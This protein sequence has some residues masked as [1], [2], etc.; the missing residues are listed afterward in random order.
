[1]QN[2]R[3]L[4]TVAKHEKKLIAQLESTREEARIIVNEAQD[5]ASILLQEAQQKLDAELNTMRREALESR[6]HATN[7]I[8][9]AG[10]EAVDAIRQ[11]SAGKMEAVKQQILQQLLPALD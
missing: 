4:E 8:E 11:E 1:M 7:A 2:S 3:L 5:A 10:H 9:V 6:E